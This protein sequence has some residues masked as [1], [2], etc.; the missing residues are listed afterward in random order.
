M[1]GEI[2]NNVELDSDPQ[3]RRALA[4]WHPRFL[5]WWN[6]V[7]PDG[8]DTS[9][10]YLRTA[11]GASA[12]GWA[13]Y[14]YVRMPEYQWGIFLAPPER[15]R[16][17][18]G[19]HADL[20]PWQQVPGELRKELRRIIVTQGDTEPASVE[21]QRHLGKT[22]PSLYDLR[23][24][25][26]V[27]VEEARHLW[28][29]VYLLHRYFGRDG[30]EEAEELLVRR[31]GHRDHPRIL[32][33]FNAPIRDWL[34]FFCFAMFT[35][36]DG[37]YQLESLSEGGFD[38]LSR[39]T[40]FMLTEEAHHMFVGETGVQRV[41]Q[42]S[43]DLMKD[44]GRADLYA[45]GAIPIGVIQKY[46]NLWFSESLDLFGAEDSSNAATY[47]A[48]GLKGRFREHTSGVYGDHR[49]LEGYYELRMPGGEMQR[50]P[51]RRAM[52]AILRDAYVQDCERGLARWNRELAARGL[53]E[54]LTLPHPAFNRKVG[55][56]ATACY[57]PQGNRLSAE[58]FAARRGAWLPTEEDRTRNAELMRAVYQPGKVAGW[59]APPAKGIN[60]QP[61]DFE[62]VRLG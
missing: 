23:N 43:A 46:I 48:A 16:I 22:A 3:L 10:V 37:K 11:I 42:R 36:R 44:S 49:A 61:L 17:G 27:N 7:G 53:G 8:F 56:F 60:G 12:D 20:D 31:S 4:T 2:P 55:A 9:Q 58:E 29:M 25:F 19:D 26:Q 40:R 14:A 18:F 45:L 47:F 52:N 59:I 39:T 54:R 5:Q 13:H 38:P 28:A 32:N 34:D 24:L 21:Q 15:R 33:A 62:Y 57:D 35:D 51:L 6:E 1:H 41:V 30:R 50:I